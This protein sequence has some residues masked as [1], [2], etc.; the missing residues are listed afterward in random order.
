LI[1]GVQTQNI[2][3]YKKRSVCVGYEMGMNGYLVLK[4][5]NLEQGYL[6]RN[7]KTRWMDPHDSPILTGSRTPLE[8]GESQGGRR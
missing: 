3:R 2:V 7:T 8:L 4:G 1:R 6:M 5:D